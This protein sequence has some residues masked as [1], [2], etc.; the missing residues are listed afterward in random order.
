MLRFNRFVRD[1]IA[2]AGV[3]REHTPAAQQ[4]AH[5]MLQGMDLRSTDCSGNDGTFVNL[6]HSKHLSLPSQT[7]FVESG[8]K[9][10]KNACST[11]RSEQVRTCMSVIRS[12]TPL[13][14]TKEDANANKI[15]AI[16]GS[17]VERANPHRSMMLDDSYKARFKS[18]EQAMT[19]EGHFQQSRIQ[20]KKANFNE[21][22][23]M[24]KKQ[25]VAQQVKPQQQTPAATGLIPIGKIFQTKDGH[26][27]ALVV[28]LCHRGV[29][30][31]E[32]QKMKTTA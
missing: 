3:A 10:A 2:S 28:E 23:S 30:I 7:Q 25:N 24:Y 21:R 17:A 19:K 31:A 5:A 11:D 6:M 8:V 13:H 4:A 26:M 29:P 15:R 22:G 12:A 18:L 32:V 9:D 20:K 14:K 27:E 1:K 16:I